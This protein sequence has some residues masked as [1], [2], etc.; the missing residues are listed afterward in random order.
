MEFE[1]N[2]RVTDTLDGY[3]PPIRE[4]VLEIRKL[5]IKAAEELDDV[6]SLT[7]DLKWGEPSYLTKTGSTV[8]VG[9]KAANPDHYAVYFHCQTTLVD[10]F[11]QVFPDTF[12]FEGNRAIVF[13]VDDV[14]PEN[15]LKLC[16]SAAL[17]YHRVKGLPLLGI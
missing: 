5:I 10:T 7:E 14:I 2:P 12:T 3:P 17:Q 11:R 1:S 15:E 8:R 6:D 4:R 16:I 9:W 13:H